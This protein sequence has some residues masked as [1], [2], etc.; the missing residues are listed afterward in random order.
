MSSEDEEDSNQDLKVLM[1]KKQKK[2]V[3]QGK[4]IPQ[5]S[6]IAEIE[7]DE[8][9]I[10]HCSCILLSCAWKGKDSESNSMDLEEAVKSKVED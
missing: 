4:E 3:T 7:E 6:C 10:D 5:K 1:A 9:G 2:K 8:T